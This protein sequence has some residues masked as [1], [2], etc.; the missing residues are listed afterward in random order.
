MYA[1]FCLLVSHGGLLRVFYIFAKYSFW[2]R[3]PR[4]NILVSR[5]DDAYETVY[6]MFAEVY[7]DSYA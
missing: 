7:V 5:E 1:W 2:L 6:E 3:V 4:Y